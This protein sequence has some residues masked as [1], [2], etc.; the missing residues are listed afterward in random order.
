AR[1]VDRP[2]RTAAGGSLPQRSAGTFRLN[3]LGLRAD[4]ERLLVWRLGSKFAGGGMARRRALAARVARLRECPRD[5]LAVGSLQLDRE[6]RPALVLVRLGNAAARN[7]V[8]RRVSLPAA[9]WTTLSASPVTGADPLAV[10]LADI[11][12]HARGGPHQTA[13]R[14]LLA[15]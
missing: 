6:C 3:L 5:D 10:S 1:S 9:R 13:R 8:S 12:H 4:T 7:W 2:S 15:G 14:R 11:S